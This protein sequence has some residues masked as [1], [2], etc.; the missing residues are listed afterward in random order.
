MKPRISILLI[1]LILAIISSFVQAQETGTILA[2]ATVIS[3][4][5]VDGDRNLNFGSVLPGVNKSVNKQVDGTFA[6]QWTITGSPSAEVVIDFV[7]PNFL[8]TIDS[9]ASLPIA[10]GNA[11]AAYDN[12]TGGGQTAP[13]G[14]LN[15]NGPSAPMDLGAADGAIIVWIGGTVMPAVWQ[16]GGDYSADVI[17]TAA[18]TGN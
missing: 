6:G 2:T 5:R 3:G 16:T 9:T 17:L 18:Y 4:L 12:G 11:D 13:A 14:E 10:F 1:T 8:Y 7:L 15:P